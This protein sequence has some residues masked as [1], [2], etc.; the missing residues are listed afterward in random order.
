[1][2]TQK[3][4]RRARA[5]RRVSVTAVLGLFGAA[6]PADGLLY[7]VDAGVGETD[8]VTLVPSDKVSQTLAIAD[9]DFSLKEQ[10]RRLSE[11]VTGN[12]TYLDFLQH[13]FGSELLGRLNGVA[14]FAL[15]PDRLVWTLQDNW[16]Q[17]QVNPFGPLVPT[18]RENIN[19]VSTGPNWYSRLGSTTFMNI[20]GLYSRADYQQTPIDNDRLQGSAQLGHEISSQSSISVNGQ[21]QR[22]FYQNTTLNVDYDIDRVFLRYELHGARTD[23]SLDAGIDKEITGGQSSSGFLAQLNA[24]R[25]VSPSVA[26]DLS[27]GRTLTDSSAGFNS[28]QTSNATSSYNPTSPVNIATNAPVTITSGVYTGDFVLAGWR[29]VRARTSLSLTGRWEKDTYV[30]EPQFDGSRD[31][32]D[33]NIERRFNHALSIQ[34]FGNLVATR[35][36]H[37]L[38]AADATN[39][40]DQDGLYGFALTLREGRGLE[41]RLRADHLSH[42]VSSG[43]GL[44]YREN[45]ILLTVGYRPTPASTYLDMGQ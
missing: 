40:T 45:R 27:L 19:Y 14:S 30:Y 21:I 12:F 7:G 31:R 28:L 10:G 17:A 1:M 36:S 2:D 22:V 15:I 8:N 4:N 18:N 43:T 29:Y 38:F 32:L 16:S 6:S 11:D 3:M 13:A 26:L 23:V 25:R 39:Y 44:G 35:Y 34:L 24:T 42:D 9:L 20:S 33:I 41:V 5:R 37:E